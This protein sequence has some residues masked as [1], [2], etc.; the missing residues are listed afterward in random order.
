MRCSARRR[1]TASASPRP[2]SLRSRRP[3]PH[4]PGEP[5]AAR[6]RAPQPSAAPAAPLRRRRTRRSWPRARRRNRR[7]RSTTCAPSSKASKAARC[8]ATA[9]PARLRRRQSGRRASC[10]SARRPA[11]RRIIEGLPFVGRSGKLLDRMLAAIGLDRTS[12]YIANIVPWR[13]PG[14]RDADAAGSGDLPAL[15]PAADRARRSRHSRLPRR[16]VGADA[17]RL[18]GRHPQDARALDELSHRHARDPRDADLPSGLSAAHAA[19]RSVSPGGIF[20]RSRRR[21]RVVL[22]VIPGAAKRRTR[23]RDANSDAASGFRVRRFAPARNDHEIILLHIRRRAAV[24][25]IL[26]RRGDHRPLP[27]PP[28]RSLRARRRAGNDGHV[29]P[30]HANAPLV[31]DA[32]IHAAFAASTRSAR[33]DACGPRHDRPP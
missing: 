31:A 24:D 29:A 6:R 22:L 20:W 4:A 8:A 30:D 2:K 26:A 5:Q 7:R 32:E 28:G 12:V 18:Q 33:A 15:H 10:S 25:Q 9:T 1:S 11:A 17:A 21:W 13:P 14:N 27:C 19:A 23:N 3:R 16:P